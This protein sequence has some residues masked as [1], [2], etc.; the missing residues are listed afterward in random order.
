LELV[1][2]VH[3]FLLPTGYST[4]VGDYILVVLPTFFYFTAFTQIVNA[5]IIISTVDMTKL[6]HG[7]AAMINKLTITIN[8][9]LYAFFIAIIIAFHFS[10]PTSSTACGS[11]VLPEIDDKVRKGLSLAYPKYGRSYINKK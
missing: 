8:L 3:F 10:G 2:A 6:R 11:R 9:I 4:E 1:R 5:W 7:T